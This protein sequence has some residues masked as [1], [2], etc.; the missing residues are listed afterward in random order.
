M[1][2]SPSDQLFVLVDGRC[3]DEALI[4]QC[5]KAGADLNYRRKYGRLTTIEL[6]ARNLPESILTWLID[7]PRLDLE[8]RDHKLG[9]SP[10]VTLMERRTEDSRGQANISDELILRVLR[11]MTHV[12]SVDGFS[13]IVQAIET[14]RTAVCLALIERGAHLNVRGLHYLCVGYMMP[15]V[16][17]ALIAANY[18][19]MGSP[20]LHYDGKSAVSL[21]DFP[22][23][24]KSAVSLACSMTTT[25]FMVSKL[26]PYSRIH[27]DLILQM[28]RYGL[29][30]ELIYV[31]TRCDMRALRMTT[32]ELWVFER[33]ATPPSRGV[34]L[35][36]ISYLRREP[37]SRPLELVVRR[38]PAKYQ[39]I[40]IR[41]MLRRGE[42]PI[43]CLRSVLPEALIK[44]SPRMTRE[45]YSRWFRDYARYLLLARE[46]KSVMALEMWHKIVEFLPRS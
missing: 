5:L 38:V 10:I 22:N 37:D 34:V 25:R 41:A 6:A 15:D 28:T 11:R 42:V 24:G 8:V 4:R 3:H 20:I 45:Y 27:T 46:F 30:D 13:L 43:E 23:D 9:I 12:V 44:W 29:V 16:V 31:F 39:G 19:D 33:W 1:A 26:L 7:E 36:I 18:K 17:D 21:S 35:A 2:R 14:R 32:H 40:L